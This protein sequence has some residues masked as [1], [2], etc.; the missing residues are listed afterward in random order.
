MQ[1]WL[2][3]MMSVVALGSLAAQQPAQKPE[4]QAQVQGPTFRSGVDVI[5][6]DVAVVDG[7]GNP[8][9]DLLRP[10]FS[11]KIDGKERR[12]VS[13]EHVK[14]DVNAAR[15]RAANPFESFYTTNLMKSDGRM[16]LLAVDQLGIRTG[17]ADTGVGL[18][19]PRQAEP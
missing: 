7:R 17:A 4:P 16:I 8:V 13:A 5:A 1:K 19:V 2:V 6:V 9:E 10:D 14:I 11:V 12:I 18:Q 15:E 3:V